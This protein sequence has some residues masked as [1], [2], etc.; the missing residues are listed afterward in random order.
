MPS[1]KVREWSGVGA[2]SGEQLS[3]SE[4]IPTMSLTSPNPTIAAKRSGVRTACGE[5]L[6]DS[7]R[8]ALLTE[9]ADLTPPLGRTSRLC[10]RR[11]LATAP[12]ASSSTACQCDMAKD[13]AK[14]MWNETRRRCFAI[15]RTQGR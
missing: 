10:S 1:P 9:D 12:H 6:G 13:M 3:P 14:A 15:R 11:S 7:G 2:S 8:P 5:Q 4:L